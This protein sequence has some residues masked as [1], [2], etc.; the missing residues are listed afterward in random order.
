V[1]L[2]GDP[3]KTVTASVVSRRAANDFGPARAPRRIEIRHVAHSDATSLTMTQR[4]DFSLR[5]ARFDSLETPLCSES[6]RFVQ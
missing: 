6:K 4:R 1:S 2:G 3:Y 5:S